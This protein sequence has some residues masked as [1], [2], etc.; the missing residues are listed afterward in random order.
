MAWLEAAVGRGRG[1]VRGPIVTAPARLLPGVPAALLDTA[2]ADTAVAVSYRLRFEAREAAHF[3]RAGSSGLTVVVAAPLDLGVVFGLHR[4]TG[5]VIW[6]VRLAT[7][8]GGAVLSVMSAFGL[9]LGEG[10]SRQALASQVVLYGLGAASWRSLV[11]LLLML[12]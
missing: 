5:Q 7:A 11:S 12:G 9:G 8:V 6:P 4:H 2:M 1:V 10:L 3:F